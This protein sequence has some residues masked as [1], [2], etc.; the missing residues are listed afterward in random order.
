MYQRPIVDVDVFL[1]D[2]PLNLQLGGQL[3]SG[4]VPTTAFADHTY[5]RL[6]NN[7]EGGLEFVSL[8]PLWSLGYAI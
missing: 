5:R 6:A 7:P 3:R 8:F 2:L 1:S 4:Q